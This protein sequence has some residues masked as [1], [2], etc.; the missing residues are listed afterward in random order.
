[1]FGLPVAASWLEPGIPANVKAIS[2]AMFAL[3]LARPAWALSVLA[4][5][6]PLA[7]KIVLETAAP[8]SSAEMAELMVVPFL[9]ATSLRLILVP[10][11]VRGRLIWPAASL[12]STIAVGG[13]LA[14]RA[15]QLP[16]AFPAVFLA[17]LRHHWLTS[18]FGDQSVFMALH[19]AAT[20]IEA[21]ALAVLAERVIRAHPGSASWVV[22]WFLGG[23]TVT[24]AYAWLRVIEVA[25]RNSFAAA[26]LWH[27]VLTQRISTLYRD[28]NAAGS[29]FAM[30]LVPAVWLACYGRRSWRWAWLAAAVLLGALWVT[31]SRMALVAAVVAVA[32]SWLAVRRVSK[33]AVALG[34]VAAVALVVGIVIWNPGRTAQSSARDSLEVR[35]RMAQI[36]GRAVAAHP[37]FG[38]G[39]GEFRSFARAEASADLIALFPAAAHG[40]NAHNNF[41]QVLSELGVVG[42]IGF[43]WMI[44]ACAAGVASAV[45]TGSGH[46][47]MIGIAGGLFAFCVTCLGGHPLLTVEMLYVFF[48]ATGMTAGFTP[49]ILDAWSPRL[50]LLLLAVVF[51]SAPIRFWHVRQE[52]DL[53]HAVIGAGPATNGEYG[54][55]Y[56]VAERHSEW[57]ISSRARSVDIPLRLTGNTPQ[58]CLVR[59]EIDGQMINTVAPV[60]DAWTSVTFQFDPARKGPVS[61]RLDLDVQGDAC[62]LIVGKFNLRE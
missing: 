22:R 57:F 47:A 18:Y 51:V 31:G 5:L 16:T 11:A 4:C 29:L 37:A 35:W 33:R 28:L 59:I 23:A 26:E 62:R 8:F 34:A 15:E 10:S 13:I 55:N 17:S 41:L 38:I 9:C 42:F 53:V 46:P 27:F 20:W 54:V 19:S 50:A 60:A 14:L 30:Y 12:A 1:M 49:S 44:G 56:R 40:E 7:P 52:A 48:L 32:A 61:R 39:L 45:R 58:P 25:Q 3:A 36:A 2:A 6:L 21:L 43:L 24:A